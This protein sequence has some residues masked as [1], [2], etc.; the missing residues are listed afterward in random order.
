MNTY[1]VIERLIREDSRIE[2]VH[3]LSE[4]QLENYAKT[5]AMCGRMSIFAGRVT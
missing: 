3:V 4:I 2:A 1:I 5:Q